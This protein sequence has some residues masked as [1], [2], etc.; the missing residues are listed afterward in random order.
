MN[1]IDVV[2][3]NYIADIRGE[4]IFVHP[5][6]LQPEW[7]NTYI[8]L[9]VASLLHIPISKKEMIAVGGR[10]VNILDIIGSLDL[11]IEPAG[12]KDEDDY[13]IYLCF[14]QYVLRDLLEKQKVQYTN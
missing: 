14:P 5:A 3:F 11:F 7:Y 2:A 13:M 8:S 6:V 9:L 10:Q 12:G 1:A 4:E